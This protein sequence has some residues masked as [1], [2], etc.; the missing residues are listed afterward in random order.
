MPYSQIYNFLAEGPDVTAGRW[1]G[2]SLENLE[3][4]ISKLQHNWT[5]EC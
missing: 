2:E 3:N 5:G 1:S 4:E